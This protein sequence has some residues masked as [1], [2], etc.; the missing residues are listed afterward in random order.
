MP[1]IVFT[2]SPTLIHSL[3]LSLAHFRISNTLRTFLIFGLILFCACATADIRTQKILATTVSALDKCLKWKVIGECFWLNCDLSGC[4]V[5]ISAKVGHYRPDSVVSVYPNVDSHPWAETKLLVKSAFE[6]AK[7]TLED[8]VKRWID[9]NGTDP[10]M[11]SLSRTR[12]LRYFEADLFGHPLIDL[13]FPGADYICNSVTR[14]LQ[15]YYISLLD[16]LAWRNPSI[17]GLRVASMTPGVR[18]V[19][20]WPVN[21]WGPVFPRSGWITQSSPP[22]GAAVVAQR[23]ADIA[24]NGGPLRIRTR[25]GHGRVNLWP[26]Y[27]LRENNAA[28]AK[29]QMIHPVEQKNCS[30]FGSSDLFQLADWGGGKVD[31]KNSYL[32][33]LWRPY[34]CCP[35][36]GQVFLGSDDVH[37]YP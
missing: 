30:V 3:H 17:E 6:V 21:T 11:D 20:I 32:W 9:G 35:R 26:P 25:M 10:A 1:L 37:G 7:S 2:S 29:W 22:K 13:E 15:P 24:V 12:N 31:T 4:S 28:T 23:A 36:R 19:G 33:S 5:R 27:R 8:E 16:L 18:E 14:P 34:K